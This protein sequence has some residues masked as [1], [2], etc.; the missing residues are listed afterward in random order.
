MS[1]EHWV[2]D[3][4][5]EPPCFVPVELDERGEIESIVFGMNLLSDKC[6]GHLYAV[7]HEDGQDAVDAWLANPENVAWLSRATAPPGGRSHE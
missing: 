4:T 7:I 2:L 5:M 6:P 1:W 3:A